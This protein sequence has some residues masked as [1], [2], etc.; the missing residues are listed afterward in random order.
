MNVQLADLS[1]RDLLARH[2]RISHAEEVVHP[3][4]HPQGLDAGDVADPTTTIETPGSTEQVPG[5]HL[6]Q[7][8]ASV[9]SASQQTAE[10]RWHGVRDR[11]QL[12]TSQD[13]VLH[14]LGDP[15]FASQDD[16][17][18]AA[19]AEP[20]QDSFTQDL[21]ASMDGVE[22]DFPWDDTRILSSFLPNVPFEGLQ[23]EEANPLAGPRTR[24]W[25]DLPNTPTQPE[26]LG[27]GSGSELASRLPSMEPERPEVM[28]LRV[29]PKHDQDRGSQQPQE[30]RQVHSV[31]PWKISPEDYTRILGTFA[32]I[33]AALPPSFSLPSK[34][35][36]SRCL[37]GYFRGFAIH[38]PFLH[39]VTF[40][41]AST[42]PELLLAL[43]AIG[44]LYRF[45]PALAYG[46]YDVAQSLITWHM[47]QRTRPTLDRLTNDQ[48]QQKPATP[49]SS[50]G[51]A[52][53]PSSTPDV[54]E[55]NTDCGALQMLQ[56]MIVL[57]AMASWGDQDLTRDALSMSSQVAMLVRELKICDPETPPAPNQ[58][59]EEGLRHEKRRRT[60]F[61]AFSLL[62]LQ[63]VAFNVPPLLLNQ[64]IAI[65][66][67]GCASSWQAPTAA[68]WS[69]LRDTHMPPRP[70][71]EKLNELLAGGR[72]HHEAALSSF[73]NYALIH[74]LLQQVLLARQASASFVDADGSL[75]DTFVETMH[76][77]FHAWQESWEATYESTTDPS[78]PK[79][80]L[81]FNATAILRLAY[82]RL[83]A[84]SGPG[85]QLLLTQERT[86]E[87]LC[88]E[89]V[90]RAEDR[91]SRLDQAVLQC[92]HAL[93][94]PVRV[95]V[96]FVAR[97]QTMN[98]SVEHAVSNL[99]CAVFLAQ[100]LLVV[101]ECVEASGLDTMRLD[102]RR[103]VNT[104]R[105][106]VRETELRGRL[107][108]KGQ[109]H[110][111]QVRNLAGLTVQL[112]A[113]V[114]SGHHVFDTVRLQIK[115][116]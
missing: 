81:G 67:P 33:R 94:I 98:W 80:P 86:A 110:A 24:H 100:W 93:S 82:I 69:T 104:A 19:F 112:W 102:E 4:D 36:L 54:S 73:G 96:S 27:T 83:H 50:T 75:C 78:S 63:S 29:A 107:D 49:R 114:F 57:M 10:I 43:S 37:E 60:L 12:Q 59:W 95:G 41:A 99:E 52:V 38:L 15:V 79:G 1:D 90:I 113:Q 106:L 3:P 70:F 6:Q 8:S 71:Q 39:A 25:E 62:N 61:A 77:A 34:Y 48:Q 109:S 16:N 7:N 88:A 32:G 68:E 103:L 64:E 51:F 111:V 55:I 97:T 44:A 17:T 56:A 21:F 20:F 85:R 87:A 92:I 76:R 31:R 115:R 11:M 58:S 53:L 84:N 5:V 35:T 66:L 28:P 91:S 89:R 13:N 30:Q 42:A 47:R 65:N 46:L 74:G 45:E 2:Q 105:S 22:F 108:E 72:I 26:P 23:D 9:S 40:S 18:T 116:H 14:E 101:S